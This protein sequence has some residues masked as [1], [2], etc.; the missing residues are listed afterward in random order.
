MHCTMCR[1]GAFYLYAGLALLGWVLFLLFLP[2]TQGRWA[3]C[4]AV[5]L[6]YQLSVLRCGSGSVRQIHRVIDTGD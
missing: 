4:I 6:E 1:Y 3:E 2:E 5:P